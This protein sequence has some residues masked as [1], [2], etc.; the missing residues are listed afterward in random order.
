MVLLL[1]GRLRIDLAS[2]VA[3][4]TASGAVFQAS[5]LKPCVIEHMFLH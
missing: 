5:D 2:A 3:R 1:A 4:A